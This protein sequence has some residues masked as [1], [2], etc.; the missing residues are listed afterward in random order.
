MHKYTLRFSALVLGAA[1]WSGGLL[2]AAPPAK[3]PGEKLVA[4]GAL[5][6]P[7]AEEA[8]DQA[9]AWLKQAGKRSI[10][11]ATRAK[12]EAI[13]KDADR[14]VLD[15]VS[16]TLALGDPQGA[17]RLLAQARDPQSP[18]PTEVPA[19]LK[20]TT[21]DAFYRSNLA[22][23]Y[24]K[25]LSQREVYEES[26][27]TLK[28]VRA[29]DVVD[30]ATYLYHRGLAEY[31]LLDKKAARRS[32]GQLHDTPGAP[33]RYQ[34]LA[35]LM[36][37]DMLTWQEKD[38]NWV[39]LKMRTSSRR[40]QLGR[41]GPQT[42]KVQRDIVHRLDEMIKRLENERRG[43]V[44]GKGRGGNK[45]LDDSVIANDGK[46]GKG[47]V[48]SRRYKKFSKNWVKL[49]EKERRRIVQEL[50]KDLPEKHKRAVESYFKR[51]SQG[52]PR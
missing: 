5:V 45:P 4:F 39:A 38:L 2:H 6:P 18:A 14:P 37:E 19:V 13:W 42:Q 28:L 52:G 8:R 44:W 32:L 49:P 31:N 17:G 29:E 43:V 25:A 15:R 16:D 35:M 23:A 9:E 48:D 36:L 12:F 27:A 46:S 33:E 20:D 11:S 50:T 26:L 30:P 24:A 1:V 47:I 21:Q 7:T 51:L 10:D 22:L 40:L 3:Q 34:S 41:G